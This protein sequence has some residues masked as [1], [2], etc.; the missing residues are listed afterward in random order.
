M[1]TV[2]RIVSRSLVA[3]SFFGPWLFAAIGTLVL[4][5]PVPATAAP[6][7]GRTDDGSITEMQ[8]EE[9][10]RLPPSVPRQDR[11]ATKADADAGEGA[12][13]GTRA[14]LRQAQDALRRG[15]LGLA[16]ELLE[17][18]E[19]AM[20]NRSTTPEGAALPMQSARL[21]HI[22]SARGALQNRDRRTAT[23]EI[24]LALGGR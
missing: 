13:I 21:A 23:Q 10:S 19:T 12:T 18:A 9:R 15:N 1:R 17:R 16:N 20:L 22:G 2:P 6:P 5:A 11:D 3:P 4:A 14:W 24:D 8:R 7:P